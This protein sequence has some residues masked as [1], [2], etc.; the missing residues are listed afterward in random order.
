M[1]QS[2]RSLERLAETQRARLEDLQRGHAQLEQAISEIRSAKSEPNAHGRRRTPPPPTPPTPPVEE[3]RLLNP[4]TPPRTPQRM[5]SESR[6]YETDEASV[7]PRSSRT[8]RSQRIEHERSTPQVPACMRSESESSQMVRSSTDPM[9]KRNWKDD[10][11]N[12]ETG[13]EYAPW[14]PYPECQ[15]MPMRRFGAGYGKKVTTQRMESHL[16]PGFREDKHFQVDSELVER[17]IGCRRKYAEAVKDHFESGLVPSEQKQRQDLWNF[18]ASTE[19]SSSRSGRHRRESSCTDG[20]SR[21]S[22]PS[23]R[24][25]SSR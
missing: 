17:G 3:S 4:L 10:P 11:R 18:D 12:K 14:P 25:R 5:H 21:S 15:D 22:G 20:S 1:E 2:L 6:P 9:L 23:H 13:K 24:P 16:D 19:E 8:P 7:T